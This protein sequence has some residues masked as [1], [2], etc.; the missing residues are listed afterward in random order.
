MN[1]SATTPHFPSQTAVLAF[2]EQRWPELVTPIWRAAKLGE[3]VGEVLGAVIKIDEGRKTLADLEMEC[4]QVVLC[5]MALAESVG[6]DLWSAVEA[7]YERA[8]R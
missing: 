6:F 5:T 4:A 2:I 8:T 3:E 1:G 7:E